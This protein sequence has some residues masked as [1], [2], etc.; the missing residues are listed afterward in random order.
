MTEKQKKQLHEQLDRVIERNP[1]K[2]E[3]KADA[4]VSF[5]QYQKE[6]GYLMY[7]T[8]L[9]SDLK[10]LGHAIQDS[11][12]RI[13]NLEQKHKLVVSSL[14]RRLYSEEALAIGLEQM[15]QATL[16]DKPL[17]SVDELAQLFG[18]SR[19]IV[20]TYRIP[21]VIINDRKHM[22]RLEDVMRWVAE[23]TQKREDDQRE[24]QRQTI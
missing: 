13:E 11:C 16:W 3:I 18:V 15:Q 4:I 6:S 17:L 14:P 10:R 19:Q 8:G 20:K 22:Y 5:E 12:I 24:E 1:D 9:H 21:K 2:I 23:R 7:L